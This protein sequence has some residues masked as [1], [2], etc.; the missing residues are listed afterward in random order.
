MITR[1]KAKANLSCVVVQLEATTHQHQGV[2][3]GSTHIATNN[4]Y[5]HDGDDANHDDGV[6]L[7]CCLLIV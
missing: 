3:I 7:L 5:D 1:C 6:F 4:G 2:V